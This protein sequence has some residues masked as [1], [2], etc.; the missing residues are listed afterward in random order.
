MFA[1][2]AWTLL[3]A[4]LLV[5]ALYFLCFGRWPTA[6]VYLEQGVAPVWRAAL[7]RAPRVPDGIILNVT[8]G[9]L[10]TRDGSN[11]QIGIFGLMGS[12]S[13]N[14]RAIQKWIAPWL[15]ESEGSL[16]QGKIWEQRREAS[17][18]KSGTWFTGSGLQDWLDNGSDCL[19]LYGESHGL[20]KKHAQAVTGK[21]LLAFTFFAWDLTY[22]HSKTFVART[23]LAL[24]S[25]IDPLLKEIKDAYEKVNSFETVD[26]LILIQQILDR[27]AANSSAGRVTDLVLI[28]DAIDEIPSTD[29]RLQALAMLKT[30]CTLAR[31]SANYRLRV[32]LTSRYDKD[33]RAICTHESGWTRQNI[34]ESRIKEDIN[35]VLEARMRQNPSLQGLVSQERFSLADKIVHKSGFSFRLASMYMDALLDSDLSVLKEAQVTLILDDLPGDL[36]VYY[37]RILARIQRREVRDDIMSA[38]RLL[39]FAAEPLTVEQLVASC[40]TIRFQG[41]DRP[42]YNPGLALEATDLVRLLN[43]LVEPAYSDDIKAKLALDTNMSVRMKHFSVVEWLRSSSTDLTRLEFFH[44]PAPQR[45]ITLQCFAYLVYCHENAAIMPSNSDPRRDGSEQLPFARYAA[46]NW[47]LHAAAYLQADDT[48]GSSLNQ[49]RN[50]AGSEDSEDADHGLTRPTAFALRISTAIL[51][52][53]LCNYKESRGI[54]IRL[55]KRAESLLDAG[56]VKTL[57]GSILKYGARTH[58]DNTS[59]EDGPD[60]VPLFSVPLYHPISLYPNTTRFV[61]KE[62]VASSTGSQWPAVVGAIRS[63]GMIS[64]RLVAESLDNDPK[65]IALTYAWSYGRRSESLRVNDQALWTQEHLSQWV[66]YWKED[67]R[68]E[69]PVWIDVIS[70]DMTE[71]GERTQHIQ[72]MG[73]IYSQAAKVIVWLGKGTETDWH[74]INAANGY[75]AILRQRTTGTLSNE[76]RSAYSKLRELGLNFK[77]IAIILKAPLFRNLFIYQEIALAR[78]AIFQCGPA[79]MSL[80]DLTCIVDEFRARAMPSINDSAALFSDPWLWPEISSAI[81]VLETFETLHRLR[82][83]KTRPKLPELLYILR[84]RHCDD[85]RDKLYSLIHLLQGE[86]RRSCAQLVDL[87]KSAAFIFNKLNIM[88]ARTYGPM[89]LFSMNNRGWEF[90]GVDHPLGVSDDECD[91]WP[92]SWEHEVYDYPL[93]PGAFLPPESPLHQPSLYHVSGSLH[94]SSS[95]SVLDLSV[96][97]EGVGCSGI[98]VDIITESA[99]IQ[100][101]ESIDVMIDLTSLFRTMLEDRTIDAA[102]NSKC[103]KFKRR[104]ADSPMD[105]SRLPLHWRH[106]LQ[107]RGNRIDRRLFVTHDGL[108][109]NGPQQLRRGDE[110]VVL[111]G[112]DVPHIVRPLQNGSTDT[113]KMIGECYLDR[114]MDG[115]IM[116]RSKAGKCTVKPIR[117]TWERDQKFDEVSAKSNYD[118]RDFSIPRS[119]PRRRSLSQSYSKHSNHS[120]DSESYSIDSEHSTD[121][122]YTHEPASHSFQLLW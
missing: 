28:V 65:Y 84:H 95:L 121:P 120:I 102:G 116:D 60:R 82:D 6:V 59:A 103:L 89:S 37:D 63:T 69:L 3:I 34:P 50:S 5:P 8:I 106:A 68:L 86:E 23:L 83:S 25:S 52:P 46:A 44:G 67:E 79:L 21:I 49:V 114:M 92:P 32:I 22:T 33:V 118:Q 96:G 38:L 26:A 77:S 74:N 90:A 115:Q 71:L 12:D 19:W 94:K 27:P 122:K 2:V 85:S 58:P 57:F 119:L 76:P 15:S 55:E 48:S 110:V 62:V 107:N 39:L 35:L 112:A 30:L 20:R 43:G 9:D 97:E 29:V 93:A 42:L 101:H 99:L 100:D 1:L 61:V 80:D 17:R 91:A 18:G 56:R 36:F 113:Y 4:I 24:L 70:I 109:G 104:P 45:H 13:D 11:V 47:F 54:Q 98:F 51:A 78:V 16:S 72:L 10:D 75:A 105:D 87:T 7:G 41:R 81:G 40:A 31:S 73:R 88:L 66:D 53:A 108:L 111:P 14:R 117:I 64:G